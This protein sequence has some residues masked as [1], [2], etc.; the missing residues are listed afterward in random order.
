MDPRDVFALERLAGR[1][2]G[3]QLVVAPFL[4]ARARAA[5]SR[6]RSQL[7]RCHRKRPYH[8]AEARLSSKPK[9]HKRSNA[10]EET[11][12]LR[13]GARGGPGDP[14]PVDV[15]PPMACGGLAKSLR[16]RPL[17]VSRVIALLEREAL[18][19][20]DDDRGACPPW[21]GQSYFSAGYRTIRCSH[22]TSRP[23][24][25]IRVA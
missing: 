11:S 15:R 2:L 21:T 12:C 19:D 10:R 17:P 9:V 3:G 16:L 24:S 7:C 18:V 8:A 22:P 1:D 5:S 23:A 25:S 6:C 4:S 14:G 13:G 20:R